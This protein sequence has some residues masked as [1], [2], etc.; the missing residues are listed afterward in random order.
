MKFVLLVCLINKTNIVQFAANNIKYAVTSNKNIMS[1]YTENIPPKIKISNYWGDEDKLWG[2][3]IPIPA[4]ICATAKNTPKYDI[5][6][7]L[8][9]YLI[10]Y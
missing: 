6:Y 5:L 9:I 7:L 3:C 4:T 10:F 2:G 8:I 1:H